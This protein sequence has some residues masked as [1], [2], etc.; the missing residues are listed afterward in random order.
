MAFA[1]RFNAGIRKLKEKLKEKPELA[2]ALEEYDG[3]TLTLNVT[4]DAVYVFHI[5]REGVTME[6]SPEKPPEDMYLETSSKILGRMLDEKRVNPV[7]LLT[8]KI[9]WRNI[10][11][12]EVEV[13]RRL[14]GV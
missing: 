4:D 14:L 7:D 9:R 10:G 8:G 13:V 11:L 2:E 12:R 6:V 5:S 1:E 3:R